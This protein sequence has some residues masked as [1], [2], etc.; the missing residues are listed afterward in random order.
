MNIDIDIN[1][2]INI[3]MNIN[4]NINVYIRTKRDYQKELMDFIYPNSEASQQKPSEFDGTSRGILGCFFFW[5]TQGDSH[6]SIE[7]GARKY[8][9]GGQEESPRKG[10]FCIYF[11]C[12]IVDSAFQ[13]W[14]FI[15]G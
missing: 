5:S 4:I 11:R 12:F 6:Q 8:R 10:R 2:N 3:N 15:Q 13:N 9:C 7:S 14:W 1:I